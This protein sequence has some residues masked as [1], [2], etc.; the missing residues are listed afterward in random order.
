LSV[1]ESRLLVHPFIGK[2]AFQDSLVKY[3]LI[4]SHVGLPSSSIL[5]GVHHSRTYFVS[6]LIHANIESS[7]ADE[8]AQLV[9]QSHETVG[10]TTVK[11]LFSI[12]LTVAHQLVHWQSQVHWVELLILFVDVH[13]LQP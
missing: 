9:V 3:L 13:K 10:G 2:T 6:L 8:V 11:S 5:W 12:Q 4:H 1:I 7:L